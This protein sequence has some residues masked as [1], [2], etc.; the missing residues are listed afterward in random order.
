MSNAT[1]KS[2]RHFHKSP[3]L[4]L[5]AAGIVI[6][7][8]LIVYEIANKDMRAAS[9]AKPI[10]VDAIVTDNYIRH[11]GGGQQCQ[12]IFRYD[13]NGKTWITQLPLSNPQ[14]CYKNG[15]TVSLTVDAASP[16]RITDAVSERYA[17]QSRYNS[18]ALASV[19][20]VSSGWLRW[21]KCRSRGC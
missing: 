12:P 6:L 15:S 3:E 5:F 7:G 9:F 18:L 4:A 1:P 17:K 16:Q 21:W 14:S 13:L 10:I 11:Q 19:L 2:P 20:L 8:M